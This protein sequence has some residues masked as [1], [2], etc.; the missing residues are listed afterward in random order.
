MQKVDDAAKNNRWK[1]NC[2]HRYRSNHVPFTPLST[3]LQFIHY[4][5]PKMTKNGSLSKVKSAQK[6]KAMGKKPK[7][8]VKQKMLLSKRNGASKRLSKSPKKSM[9]PMKVPSPVKAASPISIPPPP[10]QTQQIMPSFRMASPSKAIKAVRSA[11]KSP[12]KMVLLSPKKPTVAAKE[13]SLNQAEPAKK[14]Y[15]LWLA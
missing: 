1:K 3:Q 15:Y 12:K 13:V 9:T 14:W 2:V 10:H 7:E 4:P 11:S 8:S 6:A 5:I